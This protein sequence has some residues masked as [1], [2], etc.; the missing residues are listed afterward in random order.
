[1]TT[2][3]APAAARDL[4]RER[5]D[6]VVRE[7]VADL[8]CFRVADA[9]LL[10]DLVAA[11]RARRV[12]RAVQDQLSPR[13]LGERVRVL[14]GR[15]EEGRER[16][17]A[18]LEGA[19]GACAQA[20]DVDAVRSDTHQQVGAC[21]RPELADHRE[22]PFG[23]LAGEVLGQRRHDELVL[24]LDRVRLGDDAPEPRLRHLVVGAVHQQHVAQA[25]RA[26]LVLVVAG[27]QHEALGVVGKV[28]TVRVRAVEVLRAHARAVGRLPPERGLLD[29]RGHAPPHHRVLE[30]AEAQQLRHL[31][32]VAEHV[33]QVPDVHHAT[34]LGTARD[35]ELEV[36]DH[37]LARHH[38][39]V[40][41]DHPRPDCEPARARKP[42]Q[43]GRGLGSHREVVVE[44][45]GLPVEQEARVREVGLEHRE[46]RVEQPDQAQAE[47]L[48]RRVPLAV[49]VGVRDDGDPDGFPD[50]FPNGLLARQT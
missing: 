49:P 34:E 35:A 17:G 10:D 15:Q 12:V 2:S 20:V 25:R 44:H 3:V 16:L 40:H 50:G 19:F 6:R 29:R 23:R 48:E 30:A 39:L 14:R 13:D 28:A 38:E 42:R 7:P 26:Q 21:A 45:R 11:A 27:A 46:Q 36:A 43:R 9:D 5:V 33:G 47:R 22:E 24:V 31:R 32:D 41:E 1:M 4:A 37:R 8:A 18:L